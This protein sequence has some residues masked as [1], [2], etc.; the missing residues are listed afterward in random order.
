MVVHGAPVVPGNCGADRRATP[1]YKHGC[2]GEA[3]HTD[4]EDITGWH[5][6][7]D[8]RDSR[9]SPGE[10][11]VGVSMSAGWFTLPSRGYRS[12]RQLCAIEV[13]DPRLG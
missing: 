11:V 7:E 9:H 5:L 12:V 10:Q 3:R 6:F 4:T 1:I 8:L 13:Y 2:F